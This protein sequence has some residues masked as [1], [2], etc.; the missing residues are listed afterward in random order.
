MSNVIQGRPADTPTGKQF[1][2]W[3]KANLQRNMLECHT[4]AT[5]YE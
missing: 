5:F 2:K 3:L 1:K 4:V